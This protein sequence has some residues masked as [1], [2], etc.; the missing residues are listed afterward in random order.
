MSVFVPHTAE[1][2]SCSFSFSCFSQEKPQARV[3]FSHK[4]CWLQGEMIWAKSNCFSWPSPVHLNSYFFLQWSAGISPVEAWASIWLSF[5]GDCPSEGSPNAP[6][7]WLRGAGTVLQATA[8][9]AAGTKVCLPITLCTGGRDSS[10]V[11]WCMVLNPTTPTVALLFVDG[12]WRS[13]LCVAEE[14]DN[15]K[16]ILCCF[17]ADITPNVK[18]WFSNCGLVAWQLT[19]FTWGSC[20]YDKY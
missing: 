18:L 2:V 12:S 20:Q 13:W 7:P 1:G 8:G 16:S 15:I 19:G 5:T 4:L 9:S 11:P 14:G 6:G 10:H 17:G 3:S